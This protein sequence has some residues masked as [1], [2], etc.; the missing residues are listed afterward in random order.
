MLT[1]FDMRG[2][3]NLPP[4][5][6]KISPQ[7]QYNQVSYASVAMNKRPSHSV[8]ED[9]ALVLDETYANDVDLSRHV[10]G[11]AKDLNSIPNLKI[12]LTKEGFGEI[13]L[14]YLGGLWVMIELKDMET[15][16][17]LLNHIGVKS[18]FHELL[19]ATPDFVSNDRIVWVD[20]EWIPL[21][22][23]SH[24]TF[25]KIGNKWGDFMDIEE[26]VESTFARKRI[27]IKTKVLKNILE[28]F[29]VI[30][31]GKV[32]WIRAKELFTWTPCFLEY[33][34]KELNSDDEDHGDTNNNKSD[35]VVLKDN[36]SP[37][38]SD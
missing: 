12:I 19:E 3:V 38:D 13:K 24:A 22:M 23:W 14:S 28:T 7:G 15:K 20:I 32:F 8:P 25:S 10:M 9:P 35:D 21:N 29:K 30:I 5:L 2:L 4:P 16:K 36:N 1:R 31:K 26:V 33:K 37:D 18:W 6:T 34:D 27:C 11:R 17:D